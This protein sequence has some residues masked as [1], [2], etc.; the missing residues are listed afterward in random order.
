MHRLIALVALLAW[1]SPD[2]ALTQDPSVPTMPSI[3]T[4]GEALVRCAPRAGRAVDRVLRIDDTPEAHFNSP[5]PMMAIAQEADAPQTPI[6]A[7]AL[8]IRAQV[9][10]RSRSSRASAHSSSAIR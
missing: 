4:M 2:V 9:V 5:R 6:E 8:E 3:V 10:L 7:G 1:T